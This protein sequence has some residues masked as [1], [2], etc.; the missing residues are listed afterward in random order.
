MFDQAALI[1][2]GSARREASAGTLRV[3]DPA[4]D[5]LIMEL[6]KA[7]AP[8]AVEA[9]QLS[10]EGFGVWSAKPAYERYQILRHAAQ[11]M[12]ERAGAAAEM[13]T[14]E[15]GKPRIQ[16][17]TEWNS[18]AD[19]LDWSAEEGRRAYG[20][21]VPG[22]AADIS[23]SV[24]SRPVGPVAIFSP[25]NVPAWGPMQKIAPALAAGCSVVV[26]AAEETPLTAWAI[27][28]CLLDAGV[29][30]QAVSLLWGQAAEIS[31][32]LIAAPEI[33]KVSLTG[34]TRVGR[35]VAAAA[36]AALK[37]S[38]MELGGH[39]PVIVAADA[40]LDALVPLAVT[41]KY[42][43]AGQICVSPTRFLVEDAL[44]EPFVRRFTAETSKL[45]V[46][47]GADPTTTMGPLTTPGQV[48]T[49]DALVQDALAQGAT[50]ETGGA[51]IGNVGNF[52]QPTVL[53]GMTPA[54]RAMND[55]PFGPLALVMRVGSL[56]EALTE[57][58]RLP[59]GLGSY[60][61]TRSDAAASRIVRSIHAGMLGLNH[62][63]LALPETPFGGVMDSGFGAEG[64]IEAL[65]SYSMAMLVTHRH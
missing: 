10:M 33:R 58:N 46:G 54:M 34:S 39:A 38:T 4:T 65:Q 49:V 48:E 17:L 53:S 18:S 27:V 23:L 61:F 19:L 45:S 56:E 64:G 30:P 26:K 25:W 51:R 16:A 9:A 60:A 12:R 15:Q 57:A 1:I 5:A 21:I 55:E 29:T 14:R 24:L 3:T 22:R 20:R 8:E 11:L 37:K 42:R 31:E 13:M 52:Y 47:N 63:A 32:A 40:D 2:G 50:L 59:V 7:G 35:I 41:W 6:P 44:Y 36:G 43:N 28:R 62:F